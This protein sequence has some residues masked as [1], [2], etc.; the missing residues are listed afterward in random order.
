LNQ[1][2]PAVAKLLRDGCR[3]APAL[4]SGIH[5]GVKPAFL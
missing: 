3:G 1:V 5:K 2:R 4:K